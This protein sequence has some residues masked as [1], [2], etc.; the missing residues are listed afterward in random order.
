V[1]V[2]PFVQ[3]VLSALYYV[4]TLNLVVG[5]S[6][7]IDNHAEKKIY[8]LEVKVYK[9]EKVEVP[10]GKFNCWKVEPFLKSTGIFRQE[11]R[12]IVWLTDDSRKLPVLMKSKVT[13]GS[14]SVRL[15]EIKSK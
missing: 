15:Q 14:I 10:A 5:K 12:L 13:I 6:I 1:A 8:P 11:G 2:P 9:K 4:R 7:F 3:D